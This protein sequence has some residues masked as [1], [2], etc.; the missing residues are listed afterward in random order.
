MSL[1]YEALTEQREAPKY[2]FKVNKRN[3]NNL[4]KTFIKEGL[5]LNCALDMR[6]VQ[7]LLKLR[8]HKIREL[9][10]ESS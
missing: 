6:E 8:V 5:M 7:V 1:V 4:L 9:E 3:R 10:Q 2:D